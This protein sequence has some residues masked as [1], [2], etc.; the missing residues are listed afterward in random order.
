MRKIFLIAVRNILFAEDTREIH[1][2]RAE[3]EFFLC[4]VS[5]FILHTV[6]LEYGFHPLP[7]CGG[8]FQNTLL[9]DLTA[10]RLRKLGFR[11][12]THRLIPPNDGGIALGQA[13]YAMEKLNESK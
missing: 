7:L 8:V 11:L 10:A 3:L 13:V 2:E 9:M 6:R 4:D 12:L 1:R 5:H